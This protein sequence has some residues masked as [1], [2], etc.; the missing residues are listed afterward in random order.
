MITELLSRLQS[1]EP[2]SNALDVLVEVA[3]FETD[4]RVQSCRANS[5]GTKVIV[6]VTRTGR[7]V[8]CWAREWSEEPLRSQAIAALLK[9]K[10]RG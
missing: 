9:L 1:A 8:T 7:E 2:P 6:S 3:L 5:A 4:S 10:E